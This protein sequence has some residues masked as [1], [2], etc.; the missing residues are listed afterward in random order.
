MTRDSA[1][2]EP[3]TIRTAVE[4]DLPALISLFNQLGLTPYS[5]FRIIT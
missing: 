5:R 3:I 2:A 4:S 1:A